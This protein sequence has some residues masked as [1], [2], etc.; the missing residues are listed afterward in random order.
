MRALVRRPSLRL[1]E[2]ELTHME[3]RPLDVTRAFAQH[4]AYL[5]LLQ[6]HGLQLIELPELP[7]HPDGIF[8]EDTLVLIDGQ[9]VLTRPGAQSRRAEVDSVTDTLTSLGISAARIRE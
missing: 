8:V 7:Q 3:R 1:A 6:S 9:A 2:G 5:R 4:A